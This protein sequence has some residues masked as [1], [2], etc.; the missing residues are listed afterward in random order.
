MFTCQR[1]SRLQTRIKLTI[2]HFAKLTSDLGPLLGYVNKHTADK[3]ESVRDGGKMF[4]HLRCKQRLIG[5]DLFELIL[6]YPT[7]KLFRPS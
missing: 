7:G 4:T 3:L 6:V 1:A 5:G 2:T